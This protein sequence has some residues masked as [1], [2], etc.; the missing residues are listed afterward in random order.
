VRA[1][2][3]EGGPRWANAAADLKGYGKAAALFAERARL[4]EARGDVAELAADR[5]HPGNA[6]SRLGDQA[7]ACTHGRAAHALYARVGRATEQGI[8]AGLLK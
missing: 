3:D 5:A 7:T 1:I 8:L 4:S 6:H 2:A